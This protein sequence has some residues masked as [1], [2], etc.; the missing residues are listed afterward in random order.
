M[1]EKPFGLTVRAILCDDQGRCLLVRRSAASARFT[2][3]WEW[4]GGKV[5]PGEDFM[6]ALHR[7][8]AEETGLSIVSRRFVG[9]TSFELPQTNVIVLCMET[10]LAGGE[11]RLSDEHDAAEWVPFAEF[12]H[13]NLPEQMRGFMMAYAKKRGE[14]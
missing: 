10:V 7:E 14:S 3:C 1:T 12:A 8:L 2:G 6:T 13:R 9:A 4:P 5:D 11:L